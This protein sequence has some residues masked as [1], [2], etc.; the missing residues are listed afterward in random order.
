MNRRK[1]ITFLGV[2]GAWPKTAQLSDRP[3]RVG[4]LL[5]ITEN[6]P[7]AKARTEALEPGLQERGWTKGRN[8][9]VEYRW[10]GTSD[11]QRLRSYAAELA[12]LKPDVLLAGGGPTVLP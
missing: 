1:L 5:I 12:S 8:V 10:A 6:D 11:T 9:S 3:K 2:V 4:V 7:Q